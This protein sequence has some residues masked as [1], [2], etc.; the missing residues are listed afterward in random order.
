MSEHVLNFRPN[1]DVEF[2]RNKA[3][4]ELFGGAGAMRRVTDIQKS[5]N[6]NFY[7]IRWMLGPFA[8]CDHTYGMAM[9]YG[10]YKYP[11]TPP[12]T[13]PPREWVMTFPTYEGAVDHE[14][15]MLNAMR[16]RGIGFDA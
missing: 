10:V 4:S 1:G 8:G 11:P 13:T 7:H 3:L 15:R 16:K 9:D 14:V 12:K 2:T 5:E 6:G